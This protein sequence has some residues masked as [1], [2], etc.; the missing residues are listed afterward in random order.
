[1]PDVARK[2]MTKLAFHIWAAQATHWRQEYHSDPHAIRDN[3]G[4]QC[5]GVLYILTGKIPTSRSEVYADGHSEKA[6]RVTKAPKDEDT[7]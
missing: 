6:G 5:A 7:A 3:S 1:M 4:Y 2:P